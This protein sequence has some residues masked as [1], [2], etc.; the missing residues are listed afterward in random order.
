MS[1]SPS[2]PPLPA[3]PAPP[4]NLTVLSGELAAAPTTRRLPSGGDV[5]GFDVVTHVIDEGSESVVRVPVAWPEPPER[6]V[7]ALRQDLAVVVVGTVRRRFF[8]AGGTTQSRTEVVAGQVLPARR[9]AAVAALLAD[10]ADALGAPA[11][12]RR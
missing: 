10:L 8:R 5:V 12:G 4:G 3:A 1:T 9:R 6:A 11:E 2:S 7:R